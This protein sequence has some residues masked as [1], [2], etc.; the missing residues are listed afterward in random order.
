MSTNIP[1]PPAI[2]NPTNQAQTQGKNFDFMGF[3]GNILTGFATGAGTGLA[4]G[5]PQVV[6]QPPPRDNTAVYL[7][8]GVLVVVLIASIF[9]IRSKK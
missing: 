3:L 7:I 6:Q 1:P 4:G 8:G 5:G 9:F 2:Q